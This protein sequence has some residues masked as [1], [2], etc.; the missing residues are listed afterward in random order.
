[1]KTYI[2]L[3]AAVVAISTTSCKKEGCTDQ[4]ATNYNS[5]AKKD[6]GSCI[7]PAAPAPTPTAKKGNLRV[8][9]DPKFNGNPFYLDSTYVNSSGDSLKFSTVK[10]Y[11]SN[12]KLK[13]SS[14]TYWVEDESYYL[15]NVSQTGGIEILI[16]D[17][18]E[19]DYNEIT[20]TIGVD[21]ARNVSGSQ[22]GAL[23]TSNGMFWS[24]STGY[25]FMKFE[26]TSPQASSGNFTYDI[27]GFTSSN[28]ALHT[29]THPFG[30]N[31]AVTEGGN[32]KVH[33]Y[34]DMKSIFDSHHTISVSTM[35]MVHMPGTNAQ[36]VAMNFHHGFTLDHVHQ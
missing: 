18:P 10:Y 25:I 12:I 9:F 4:A 21:S 7:Y 11:I 24:W 27:G 31:L 23:S 32:P 34:V 1:M 3:L 8:K 20:Y 2:F 17:I 16:T 22:T 33:M 36:M 15:V 14:N 5:K 13:N 30:T 26:G 28:N 19:G 29:N 35:P 6:D